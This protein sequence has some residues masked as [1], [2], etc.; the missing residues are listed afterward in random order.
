MRRPEET[1]HRQVVTFLAAALGPETWFCHPANGGRRS[2]AEAGIFKAL[3]VKPGT[4][5]ILIIHAGRAYWIELKAP[6][7][8]LAS[9]AE[10]KAK[11]RISA[12]QYDTLN[13][14]FVAGCEVCV[15][16]SIDEVESA[17][18][19]WGFSMRGRIVA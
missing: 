12:D 17:L 1:F 10:S 6:P 7:K 14:L 11:P 9:G 5:D 19:G 13:D 3:G 15:C 8:I 16:R 18:L 4:P 2:K